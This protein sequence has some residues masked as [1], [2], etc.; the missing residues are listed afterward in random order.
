MCQRPRFMSDPSRT[1]VEPGEL[2][3]SWFL[4]AVSSLTLTPRF[5]ERVVPKD[6]SFDTTTSYCG[7]FSILP[8]NSP[9]RKPRRSY[10]RPLQLL[11][12]IYIAIV[13]NAPTCRLFSLSRSY[14]NI[15]HVSYAADVL[16]WREWAVVG[17]VFGGGGGLSSGNPML[18]GHVR[19]GTQ[20]YSWLH[21]AK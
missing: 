2:G 5:L 4:A 1:D 18:H 15:T 16:E 8:S 9:S 12:S 13:C 20:P 19:G 7:L 6:Q 11:P 17:G 14:G 10:L 21:C 3:D